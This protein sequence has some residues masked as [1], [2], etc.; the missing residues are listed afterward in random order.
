VALAELQQKGR[1]GRE[2]NAWLFQAGWIDDKQAE[3][4]AELGQLGCRDPR[5]F[6]PNILL[7]RIAP[8][9]DPNSRTAVA[10][11]NSKAGV[12]LN[13]VELRLP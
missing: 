13:N 6:G 2:T 1:L 7:C 10:H 3:W 9:V 5:L 4:I 12:L 8:A 11:E